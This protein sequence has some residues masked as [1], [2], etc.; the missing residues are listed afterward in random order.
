MEEIHGDRTQAERQQALNRFKS[1]QTGILV[2]TDVAAR[3]LDVAGIDHVIQYDT[4]KD[5]DSKLPCSSL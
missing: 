4:A 5:S 2:A 3:G 1:G